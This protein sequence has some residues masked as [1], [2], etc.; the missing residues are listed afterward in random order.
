MKIQ[1][2][3]LIISLGLSGYAQNAP[4]TDTLKTNIDT[5]FKQYEEKSQVFIAQDLQDSL[6]TEYYNTASGL[7]A[8]RFDN[9]GSAKTLIKYYKTAP[10]IHEILA[11]FTNSTD[12][13]DEVFSIGR[14]LYMKILFAT[15]NDG[16]VMSMRPGTP[17]KYAR[18]LVSVKPANQN[19]FIYLNGTKNCTVAQATKGLRV[20]SGKKYRV[21]IKSGTKLL[22]S[23]DVILSSQES[24]DI[25]CP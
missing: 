14:V 18:L 13:F 24:K 1:L 23:H 10:G 12:Q 17:N 3:L 20:H 21:E 5:A 25:S 7:T 16:V 9:P 11:D 22:C 2:L 4:V 6:K 19:A 15:K 8:D